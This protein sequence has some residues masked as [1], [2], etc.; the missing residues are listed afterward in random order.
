E[1]R[2]PKKTRRAPRGRKAPKPDSASAP[3]VA[4]AGRPGLRV[5]IAQRFMEER[6]ARWGLEAEAYVL[7]AQND[8]LQAEL[9]RRRRRRHTADSPA[10]STASP[11]P[12]R[13]ALLAAA[14]IEHF[15]RHP[16]DE[17]GKDGKLLGPRLRHRRLKKEQDIDVDIRTVSRWYAAEKRR[18]A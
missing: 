13:R 8:A 10:P 6:R 9:T 11:V 18:A 5:D 15:K 12:S 2:M 14:R 4:K 16:I 17:R 3:K 1:G 7:R